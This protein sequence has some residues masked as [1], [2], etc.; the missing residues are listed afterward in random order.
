MIALFVQQRL[1]RKLFTRAQ[2]VVASDRSK[3]KGQL[4]NI[5]ITHGTLSEHTDI[6]PD[7]R[8]AIF[9]ERCVRAELKL[10][11]G[12]FRVLGCPSQP[13]SGGGPVEGAGGI[14]DASTGAGLVAQSHAAGTLVEAGSPI[15]PYASAD[16]GNSSEH[17][18]IITKMEHCD[19]QKVIAERQE[20]IEALEHEAAICIV[21]DDLLAAH[22]V[23]VR[24]RVAV[25]CLTLG[26]LKSMHI[27][28]NT[29]SNTPPLAT[30]T[31]PRRAWSGR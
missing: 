20:G 7:S 15:V 29:H 26:S 30:A 18:R 10:L 11:G 16:P 9:N 8:Y 5:M 28:G 23:P 31:A 2:H 25:P 21:D 12:H 13:S 3:P 4:A 17:V 14:S 19:I 22:G 1:H 24:C 6:C 27:A